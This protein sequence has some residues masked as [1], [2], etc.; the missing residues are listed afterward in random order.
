MSFIRRKKKKRRDE[1][2]TRTQWRNACVGFS[3]YLYVCVCSCVCILYPDVSFFEYECVLCLQ[4]SPSLRVFRAR[5]WVFKCGRTCMLFTTKPSRTTMLGNKHEINC[6]GITKK[7]CV[8]NWSTSFP[9]IKRASI[10]KYTSGIT[11]ETRNWKESIIKHLQSSFAVHR[12]T[13]MNY[14]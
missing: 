11:Q 9:E 10:T 14:S 5:M 4:V 13:D 3:A 2:H 7:Q 8:L 12:I 1:K 6:V